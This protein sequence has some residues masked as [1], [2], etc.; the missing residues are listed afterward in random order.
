[1]TC[2]PASLLPPR[3]AMPPD[4]A[5]WHRFPDCDCL[6]HKT[7]GLWLEATRLGYCRTDH[8]DDDNESWED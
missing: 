2:A 5:V 1:M 8:E 4:G 3:A 6:W 7:G